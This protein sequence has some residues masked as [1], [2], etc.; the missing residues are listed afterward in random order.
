MQSQTLYSE[1]G[2]FSQELTPEG[3]FVE[4]LIQRKVRKIFS[5]DK[6]KYSSNS[7]LPSYRIWTWEIWTSATWYF[8]SV[9]GMF[10]NI[11]VLCTSSAFYSAWSTIQMVNPAY[12]DGF[13]AHL[14]W[15]WAYFRSVF[16]LPKVI[17]NQGLRTR[18]SNPLWAGVYN[19]NIWL[20]FDAANRVRNLHC[21]AFTDF[22]DGATFGPK[23]SD[24]LITVCVY[25]IVPASRTAIL[26]TLSTPNLLVFTRR[27]LT[28]ATIHD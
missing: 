24:T 25:L 14:D 18:L 27:Q 16:S 17:P 7:R 28:K 2:G 19:P 10:L 12:G 21:Y 3:Q 5:G 4:E 9:F 11:H 22:H 13:D 8:E 26:W 6:I 20:K 1:R 15:S 23:V